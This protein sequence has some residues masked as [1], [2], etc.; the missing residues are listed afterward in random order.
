M[1]AFTFQVSSQPCSLQRR[2]S[3]FAVIKRS[4][5]KS[6][7]AALQICLLAT[8]VSVIAL[9]LELAIINA[10]SI[11]VEPKDKNFQPPAIRREKPTIGLLRLIYKNINDASYFDVSRWFHPNEQESL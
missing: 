10:K 1:S 6:G 5:R 3:E 2:V 8:T 9:G 4:R 7:S 11:Y